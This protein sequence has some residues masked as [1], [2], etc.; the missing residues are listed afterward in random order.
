[1]PLALVRVALSDVVLRWHLR[2]WGEFLEGCGRDIMD[3]VA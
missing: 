1:M 3:P 2:F